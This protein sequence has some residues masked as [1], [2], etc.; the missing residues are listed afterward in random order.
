[1]QLPVFTN[2]SIAPM[3]AGFAVLGTV[4]G[5]IIRGWTSI[6]NAFASMASI[7]IVHVDLNDDVTYKVVLAYL[8]KKYRRN[9][10]GK[11]IYSSTHD[12]FR[13]GKF[14]HIP[15]ELF[16]KQTLVFWNGIIP[17]LF[18]IREETNDLEKKFI[19]WGDP[20]VKFLASI[21][22]FRYTLNL[23]KIINESSKDR[24]NMYWEKDV[25]RKF[26][27][28]K[29][30]NPS[31]TGEARFT[32]G[33]N[34][35][36]FN[37]GI[38]RLI[39]RESKE[40]GRAVSTNGSALDA[41]YFPP[42]VKELINEIKTWYGLKDWY[43]ERNIPWKRGWC[44]YGPPG[45]GKTALVRALAEDLDMPLFVYS[46]GRLTDT[47]L[48]RSWNEMQSNTPCIALFEDFDTVFHGRENIYGKPTL[49]EQITNANIKNDVAN[50]SSISKGQLSFGCL[51]NC[52]DGADKANGIFTIFTTNHIE[53]LDPALGQPKVGVD[54]SVEFISTRPGRIDK[55]IE[56][57]YM[58]VSEKIELAQKI[59]NGDNESLCE[60]LLYIKDN[61][62]AKE[63]PAQFQ[64]RCT[65]LILEKKWKASDS[66]ILGRLP[67]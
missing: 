23:D 53:K 20:K 9:K 49:S 58:Q 63:T 55:A 4:F 48:E 22:Y 34:V 29:I 6:K 50:E 44:L 62:D 21:I 24:N 31:V 38:Y 54:G 2:D 5:I 46:L 60:I 65:Q 25:H 64:E 10:S 19:S 41:L 40:L 61:N 47:D 52:I 7:F 12:S 11:R 33:N 3:I 45:T 28:K 30:P 1:M 66:T 42:K 59:M 67:L 26:F 51:L 43:K 15:Y 16:G 56:L 8:L 17:F 39:G 37:E 32:A 18:R 27:V 13:D 57:G 36:W 35:E 14:G